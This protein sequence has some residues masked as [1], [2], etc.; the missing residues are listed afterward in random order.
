MKPRVEA[1]WTSDSSC[2]KL[3][4]STFSV[5]TSYSICLHGIKKL[6]FFN[7]NMGGWA[8]N[9]LHNKYSLKQR[10]E[11]KNL[12]IGWCFSSTH[13][14]TRLPRCDLLNSMHRNFNTRMYFFLSSN[15]IF[16]HRLLFFC[17]FKLSSE[18]CVTVSYDY[19]SGKW[20]RWW[21]CW[22]HYRTHTTSRKYVWFVDN[23]FLTCQEVMTIFFEWCQ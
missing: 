21:F 9:L 20:W 11:R 18:L 10:K 16:P 5:I 12:L 7:F 8:T 3:N 1:L 13:D 22:W 23:K 6:N 17:S 2:D 14:T 4:C 19:G 15:K